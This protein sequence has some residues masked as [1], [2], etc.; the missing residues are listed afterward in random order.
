M[1]QKIKYWLVREVLVFL[2]I[3]N[4]LYQIRPC[5]KCG[6]QYLFNII[7][8]HCGNEWCKGEAPCV[9]NNCDK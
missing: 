6:K 4:G 1:F 5:E 2:N 8:C 3:K 7:K 9:C